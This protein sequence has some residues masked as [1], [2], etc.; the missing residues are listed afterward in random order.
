MTRL[1]TEVSQDQSSLDADLMQRWRAGT[2]PAAVDQ[3]VRRHGRMVLGVCHRILRDPAD[4]DDA[5]QA[6]FLVFFR[7]ARSLARPDRVAGW[8]HGVAVR[9]ACKARTMRARRRQREKTM[10]EPAAR[11]S[12]DDTS[13]LRRILDE[14]LQRLPSKYRLP[15]VLCELDGRTL[16]GAARIL[17]WPKGTVA[18]RLSRG[19]DVLRRRLSARRGLALPIFLLGWAGASSAQ[20]APSEPLVSA[21][22]AAASGRGAPHARSAALA[23]AVLRDRG[24][25]RGLLV[26]V[27]VAMTACSAL[28][29]EA[30][31]SVHHH[32]NQSD[33]PPGVTGGCHSNP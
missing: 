1:T 15:I 27:L 7:R 8:L 19:R 29:W 13:E 12:P 21:T 30:Q 14:E 33:M 28:A 6:T 31:A 11:V 20:A 9:V 18:G 32:S 3:L 23:D 17:G 5:F 26:F 22:I 4:A 2:D 25:R 16:D 24:W 10:G